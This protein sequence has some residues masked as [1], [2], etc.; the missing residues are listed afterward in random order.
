MQSAKNE[1]HKTAATELLSRA[2]FSR[3]WTYQELVLSKEVWIQC[4]RHRLKLDIFFSILLEQ[5]RGM[6]HS[7][8]QPNKQ[9]VQAMCPSFQLLSQMRDA[10]LKYILSLFSDTNQEPLISILLA[11]GG[12]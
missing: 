5:D 3:V 6:F 7:Q 8:I 10:R 11:R 1:I 2:W 9:F 12:F 4:G